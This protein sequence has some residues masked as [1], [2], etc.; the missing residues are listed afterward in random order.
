MEDVGFQKSKR[1]ISCSESGAQALQ[2]PGTAS[3]VALQR[4]RDLEDMK[5]GKWEEA[6]LPEKKNGNS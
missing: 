3:E 5:E 2:N 6:V 4:V 1:P